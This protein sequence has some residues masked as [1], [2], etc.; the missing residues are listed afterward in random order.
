MLTFDD[1]D[2]FSNP[3]MAHLFAPATRQPDVD[4]LARL[5]RI[6][7]C[8]GFCRDAANDELA[9]GGLIAAR[10]ALKS[11]LRGQQRNRR[12][13]PDELAR[14]LEGLLLAL[15]DR[16]MRRGESPQAADERYAVEAEIQNAA[17]GLI[18]EETA[19]LELLGALARGEFEMLPSSQLAE[20]A[21]TLGR[22]SGAA[23]VDIDLAVDD[24]GPEQ[25][26]RVH[27][28]I[29]SGFWRWT[30]R[31]GCCMSRNG[32]AA[33]LLPPDDGVVRA[34]LAGLALRNGRAVVAWAEAACDRDES[35]EPQT[36][37]D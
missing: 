9:E 14:V 33:V 26:V 10:R 8:L 16:T 31:E 12:L 7:A 19:D 28:V 11:V 2:H 27:L 20:L 24:A 3:S 37:P 29:E 1:L 17:D 21:G 36:E 35:A 22:F 32:D 6:V 13:H 15:G 5:T 25:L 30:A 4:T 23:T 34:L 18:S